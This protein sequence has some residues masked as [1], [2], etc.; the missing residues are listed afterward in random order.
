MFTFIA[1]LRQKGEDKRHLCGVTL[2]SMPPSPTV[3]ISAAHCVTVCRSETMN[4][5]LPNCCCDN[6][7]GERCNDDPDNEC[8]D[9]PEVVNM[10]GEDAE[11]L[12][13]E[14]ETGT[15]PMDESGEEYNIILPIK[16]IIRHPNYT[17]S[18][19]E[20]NSQFVANDLAVFMV[21]DDELKNYGDK[22]VPICLPSDS[23]PPP[24]NATHAGW[25]SPPPL[26]F[27]EQ[28]LLLYVPYYSDFF[29]MWHHMMNVTKCEDPDLD[30]VKKYVSNYKYETYKFPSNSS[31]PPGTVCAVDKWTE[32]CPSSGESGSPLMYEVNSRF[33][34]TGIQSFIKGCS[35]FTYLSIE[36]TIRS[37]PSSS[38]QTNLTSSY[39]TQ[40][41]INP[42]V[43]TK[44]SCFLSW[45]AEQYNMEYEANDNIDPDCVNYTG[46]INEVTA[47]DCRAIH[48]NFRLGNAEEFTDDVEAQCIFNFK[49][50]EKEW[51]GCIMSGIQDFSHPVFRCPIRS[52]KNRNS[53][54]FTNYTPP[55][56]QTVNEVINAVYCPTNCIDVRISAVTNRYYFTESFIYVFNSDGPVYGPNG[57]YELD[58]EN[59]GCMGQY[60]RIGLPVFGTCK[61]N[62]RGGNFTPI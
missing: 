54:Y 38:R 24:T 31:Y 26:E 27:L 39:L 29:K 15:T 2:L 22:I 36:G 11:I 59:T 33:F 30:L 44:L 45:I 61:N 35:T 49:V 13:G 52:L 62:C 43:Y 16:N 6:V 34:A 5:L 60:S 9:D 48:T 32:F 19:G 46:D 21:D 18:R 42:S 14:W 3:L 57:E 53:T 41:S 17:I 23:H 47:N 58:P 28:N 7:G 4:K 1:F 12:C 55:E 51:D 40:E 50:D 10:T 56:S 25:S 37:A 8:G 20:A